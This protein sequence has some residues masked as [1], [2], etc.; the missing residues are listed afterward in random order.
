M[1]D[2][3]FGNTTTYLLGRDGFVWAMGYNAGRQLGRGYADQKSHQERERVRGL[4]RVVAIAAAI[5]S[6]YALD[7]SGRLWSWGE[8]AGGPSVA[9][10]RRKDWLEPGLVARLER[11]ISMVGGSGRAAIM[12]SDG[13]VYFVGNSD[14]MVRG[15]GE[16]KDKLNSESWRTPQRSLWVWK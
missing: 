6:A 1:S 9:G 13:Y 2:V 4:G 14:G 12:S 5:S 16:S 3:S 7:E 11:P 15:V 8:S 10:H